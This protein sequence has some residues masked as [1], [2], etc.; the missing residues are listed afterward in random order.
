MHLYLVRHTTPDVPLGVCYGQT[1]VD[2][3]AS[4]ADEVLQVQSNLSHLSEACLYS[5]PLQRCKK[6]ANQFAHLGTI[7]EDARLKELNFGDWEMRPW[8]T[9]PQGVIETWADDHVRHAPPN[10]EAF[11]ALAERCQHFFDEVRAQSAE[12]VVV[13][14]HAGVIRAL[15]SQFLGMPL[16]HAFRLQVDYGR[17]THLHCREPAPALVRFNV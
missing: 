12:H 14:T 16:T 13:F 11:V 15:L 17:V 9:I 8:S 4:F 10:G 3:A 5:S 2:V 1:D 7:T 6:L